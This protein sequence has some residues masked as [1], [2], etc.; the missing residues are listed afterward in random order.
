MTEHHHR[1][2]AAR[3]GRV[4]H[5]A[6]HRWCAG[7][8]ATGAWAAAGRSPARQREISAH[9]AAVPAEAPHAAGTGA[10]RT[11]GSPSPIDPGNGQ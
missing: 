1:P 3:P 2:L 7:A 6:H 8:T 5:R 10:R 9:P 4:Q 11:S